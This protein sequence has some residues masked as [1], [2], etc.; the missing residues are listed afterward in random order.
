MTWEEIVACHIPSATTLLGPTLELEEVVDLLTVLLIVG[1]LISVRSSLFC[2]LC[3]SNLA[4]T[5]NRSV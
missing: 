2:E 3:I 1:W 4:V 5:R